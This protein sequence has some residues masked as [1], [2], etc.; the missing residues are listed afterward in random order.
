MEQI[1]VPEDRRE[2][3]KGWLIHDRKGWL[4]HAE[5]AR[6]LELQYRRVGALS[7]V[8]SAVVGAS[9]FA[10]LETDFDAWGRII[11]GFVSVTASVLSGLLTFNRYEERTEKHRVAAVRY[12]SSLKELEALLSA[13]SP[14][15]DNGTVRRIEQEFKDL[16]RSAPVIPPKI[17]EAIEKRLQAFKFIDEAEKLGNHTDA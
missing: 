10:S 15:I 17:D 6:R 13:G 2:L 4:K 5:A 9:L 16:E 8:L 3:L 12:K 11:S 7:V 1:F 14:D